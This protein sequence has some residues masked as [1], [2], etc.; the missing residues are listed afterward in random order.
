MEMSRR[1]RPQ[2]QDVVLA[3]E[4]LRGEGAAVYAEARG[5]G[6]C[7][8]ARPTATAAD[9]VILVDLSAGDVVIDLS[10]AT[11]LVP[12]PADFV[13]GAQLDIKVA[14]PAAGNAVTIAP[15]GAL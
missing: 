14:G 4:R 7:R 10:E 13:L 9:G 8:R 12:T 15:F 6:P 11:P 1:N 2:K 3:L 5:L